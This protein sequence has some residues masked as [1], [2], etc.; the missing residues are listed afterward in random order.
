MGETVCFSAGLGTDGAALLAGGD[1]A[2]LGGTA[3]SAQY[4]TPE[5]LTVVVVT[6]LRTEEPPPD[7]K[8]PP[9]ELQILPLPEEKPPL[10]IPPPTPQLPPMTL[11]P[12]T[13][14]TPPPAAPPAPKPPALPLVTVVLPTTAAREGQTH[15]TA[16]DS[17][18]ILTNP[19]GTAAQR[20]G[21][22]GTHRH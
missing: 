12:P 14:H 4:F 8:F 11:P 19:H 17:L 7:T 16:S 15:R 10:R 22:A 2:F 9:P 1:A 6:H 3:V 21:C 18:G 5:D 20:P 13:A